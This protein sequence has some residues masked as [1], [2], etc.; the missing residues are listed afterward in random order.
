MNKEL[1]QLKSTDTSMNTTVFY[2]SK[3]GNTFSTKEIK[4]GEFVFADGQT[5]SISNNSVKSN[6]AKLTVKCPISTKCGETFTLWTG[7]S[8]NFNNT[9]MLYLISVSTPSG[10]QNRFTASLDVTNKTGTYNGMLYGGDVKSNL[11]Y[12]IIGGLNLSQPSYVGTNSLG[13]KAVSTSVFC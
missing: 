5:M 13:Q 7:N 6:S 11:G 3:D 2:L 9:A 12:S 10:Y 8:E 4:Q 1:L